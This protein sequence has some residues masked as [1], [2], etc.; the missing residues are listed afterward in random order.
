MKDNCSTCYKKSREMAGFSQ[1]EAAERLYICR[2]ILSYYETGRIRVPDSI[3]IK[4]SEIY[5]DRSLLVDHLNTLD[6][7][8]HI[9]DDKKRSPCIRRPEKITS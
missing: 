6:I 3:A 9:K 7:V 2:R 1:D 4:M 5:E 8:K